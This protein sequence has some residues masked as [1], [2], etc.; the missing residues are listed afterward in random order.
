VNPW[1]ALAL[2]RIPFL[3]AAAVV[4]VLAAR[5]VSLRAQ[6]DRAARGRDRHL[7]RQSAKGCGRIADATWDVARARLLGEPFDLS[8]WIEG[9][10]A[11]PCRVKVH[12]EAEGFTMDPPGRNRAMTVTGRDEATWTLTATRPGPHEIHVRSPGTAAVL[13]FEISKRPSL[14][15]G[16]AVPLAV[17]LVVLG[18]LVGIPRWLRG[19]T[20]P[21]DEGG[22]CT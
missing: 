21:G 7:A 1:A 17:I 14:P 6:Q 20:P 12:L 2:L 8:I 10:G 3:L 4:S 22:A 15:T 5:D 18:F 19:R 13:G 16:H 11:E 9:V